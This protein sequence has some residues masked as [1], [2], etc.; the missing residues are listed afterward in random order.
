MLPKKYISPLEK[1]VYET[2]PRGILNIKKLEIKWKPEENNDKD[3]SSQNIYF[4]RI[5]ELPYTTIKEDYLKHVL[6]YIWMDWYLK[7]I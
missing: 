1:A 3:E 5:R 6:L 7:V 2:K 4:L